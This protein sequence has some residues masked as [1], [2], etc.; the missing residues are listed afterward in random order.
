MRRAVGRRAKKN[1]RC[2]QRLSIS[3]SVARPPGLLSA[4]LPKLIIGYFNCSSVRISS[5]C[6]GCFP[7]PSPSSAPA[8]Q[9]CPFAPPRWRR[10]YCKQQQRA[11]K[12]T[13]YAFAVVPLARPGHSLLP[14]SASSPPQSCFQCFVM[15][16]LFLNELK[17]FSVI[18]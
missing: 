12:L 4:C 11:E 15:D 8:A 9:K 10:A 1:E 14:Q 16:H 7:A 6:L 18:N 17:T 3:I 13:L 2:A 5:F